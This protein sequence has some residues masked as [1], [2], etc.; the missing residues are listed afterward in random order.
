MMWYDRDIHKEAI[1]KWFQVD[2]RLLVIN[3]T[4]THEIMDI[5]DWI[6]NLRQ[7]SIGEA[8]FNPGAPAKKYALLYSLVLG[9]GANCNFKN[10]HDCLN[11]L[12]NNKKDNKNIISQTIADQSTAG[13]NFTVNDPCQIAMIFDSEPKPLN[14]LKEMYIDEFLDA[15]IRD[16]TII[17]NDS[18]LF[19][20]QFF[21]G[22]FNCFTEDFKQWFLETFCRN[23]LLKNIKICILNQG[24]LDIMLNTKYLESIGEKIKIRDICKG[25]KPYIQYPEVFAETLASSFEMDELPYCVVRRTFFSY[26]KRLGVKI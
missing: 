26:C 19:L 5:A 11:N 2:D 4:D 8:R 20:I 1:I 25:A 18:T 6:R 17:N 10:F 21:D 24:N 13:N 3:S 15:F 22:G 16:I 12:K 9:L 23:L 7:Y 14:I